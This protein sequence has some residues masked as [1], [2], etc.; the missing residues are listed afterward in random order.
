LGP[1]LRSGLRES[2]GEPFHAYHQDGRRARFTV[3]IC[4]EFSTG[5]SYTH[6]E[7]MLAQPGSLQQRAHN[8]RDLGS[9]GGFQANTGIVPCR[10]AQRRPTSF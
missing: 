3:K 10:G 6:G 1:A 2:V 5:Y 9:L 7:F 8:A 4:T